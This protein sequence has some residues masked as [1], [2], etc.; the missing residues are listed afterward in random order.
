MKKIYAIPIAA[1]LAIVSAVFFWRRRTD[2]S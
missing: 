1:V 2:Q